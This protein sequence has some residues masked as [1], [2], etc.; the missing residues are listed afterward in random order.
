[1]RIIKI[2]SKVILIANL[3]NA[4]SLNRNIFRQ[5]HCESNFEMIYA[6]LC[7]GIAEIN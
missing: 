3:R 7:T 5:E 1:M 4:V 6:R 2:N